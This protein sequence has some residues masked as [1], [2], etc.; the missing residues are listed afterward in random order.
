MKNII[1]TCI[2][3]SGVAEAKTSSHGLS[4]VSSLVNNITRLRR[5][6]AVMLTFLCMG[7]GNA[8]ASIILLFNG[9]GKLVGANDIILANELYDVRFADG[10]CADVYRTCSGFLFDTFDAAVDASR[11]LRD[12]V[13]IDGPLGQIDTHPELTYGCRGTYSCAI[14]S[15][16]DDGAGPASAIV[17]INSK[18]VEYADQIAYIPRGGNL[19]LLD[20]I[21]P[22]IRPVPYE[23]DKVWA[24][25]TKQCVS[26]YSPTNP[27]GVICV[28]NRNLIFT[29]PGGVSEPILEPVAYEP[30]STVPEPSTILLIALPCLGLACVRRKLRTQ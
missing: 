22:E 23:Q 18:F 16:Y 20:T 8:N 3:F 9:D 24:V 10:K 5:C 25:W 4:S 2:L 21:F 1:A 17:A 13:L 14:F 12:Q 27:D 26:T 29:P 28:R 30:P 6:L 19:L 7:A 15:P 11:A